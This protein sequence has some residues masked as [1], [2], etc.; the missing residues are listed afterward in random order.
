MKKKIIFV[1]HGNICRS[2]MAEYVMKHLVKEAGLENEF[3]ITSGAVSTEEIGNDIYP[4]AKRKLTEKGIVFTRHA[5]HKIT[6][7]EFRN[8][9]LV[10]LMDRSNQRLLSHIVR[11][12]EN[13]PAG[14]ALPCNRIEGKVHL[15]ME[16]AGQTRD[17]AD[18]WY[19]GDFEQTY[20]DVLAGCTGLLELIK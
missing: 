17:V 4:P 7:D 3:E 18:P 16:F 1:C 13:V 10:I 2:P 12:L 20:R 6:P 8:Q 19:T 5:A 15:M 11:D 14:N 9:D